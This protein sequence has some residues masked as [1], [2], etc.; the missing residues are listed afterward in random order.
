MATATVVDREAKLA[1]LREAIEKARKAKKGTKVLVAQVAELEAQIAADTKANTTDA[2][3]RRG[4]PRTKSPEFY[5]LRDEFKRNG[6]GRPSRA[7]VEA[8]LRKLG[9][10]G[11]LHRLTM[12]EVEQM[13][14]RTLASKLEDL[15]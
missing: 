13:F 3:K 5:A 7:Q 1:E 6:R 10:E 12:R 15:A 14:K 8:D 4:R 11:P 2:P 9:V